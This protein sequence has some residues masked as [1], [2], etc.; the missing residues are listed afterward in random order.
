LL[1]PFLRGEENDTASQVKLLFI[2]VLICDINFDWV[3]ALCQV[4]LLL[5]TDRFL[6]W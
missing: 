6:G 5:F 3:E 2:F 1:Y 4:L